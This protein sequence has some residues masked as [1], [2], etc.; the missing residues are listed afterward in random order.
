[1]PNAIRGEAKTR[2]GGDYTSSRKTKYNAQK[3]SAMP[4]S[5]NKKLIPRARE[6]RKNMTPQEKHLWYDF[7]SSYPIRFQRQKTIDNFIVDFYCHKAKLIIELDGSQHFTDEG[8]AYD[9]KR[10][11]VLEKLGLE[12][13]RFTNIEIDKEF[14][15]VC[16]KIDATVVQKIYTQMA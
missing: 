4:L 10:T 9:E 6:L 7:L 1:M 12:V 16:A 8:K 11:Q 3:E 5:Y 2:E 13:L 15:G 14:N